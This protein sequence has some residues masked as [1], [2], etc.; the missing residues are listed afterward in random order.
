MDIRKRIQ[1][2]TDDIARHDHLYYNLDAP[3]VDDATYDALRRELNTLETEYPEEIQ[4]NSPRYRVG[5]SPVSEFQKVQHNAPMLS[6]DNVFSDQELDE[7]LKRTY[8]F[9]NDDTWIDFVAEPKIDGLS[10]S[11]L[12]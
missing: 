4:P 12:Y 7:F 5:I 3:Q 1:Q 10:A 9:L 8:R 6:L 11:L 2:L